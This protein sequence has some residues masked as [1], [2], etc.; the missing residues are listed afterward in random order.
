MQFG[1]RQ[2]EEGEPVLYFENISMAVLNEGNNVRM[3]RGGWANMPRVIWDDRTE[4]TFTMTEG[5]MSQVSMSIL[6]GANMYMKEK[7]KPIFIPIKEGPFQLQMIEIDGVK[8][9]GFYIKHKPV[10]YPQKKVFI[11]EYYRD[12]VQGKAY[13]QLFERPD[14]FDSHKVLYFVSINGKEGDNPEDIDKEYIVDYYYEYGEEALIYTLQKERFNG[15]FTLEGRFYTKDENEGR[16]CTN[17][18][19]MPKVKIAS[20]INL[21]LGERA[22]PTVSAFNILGL[23]ETVGDYKNLIVDITRLGEDIE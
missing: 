5:I 8:R 1:E 11:M 9:R 18:L 23:P 22:D 19:Y 10:M 16:N 7:G 17:I 6:L 21:R 12:T 15:L 20:N 3:A 4:V 2:I 13:G 14:P